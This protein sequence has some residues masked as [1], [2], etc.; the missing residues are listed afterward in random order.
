MRLK[1][2]TEPLPDVSQK[3][4]DFVDS[5]FF[6]KHQRL[7]SP[8]QVRAL[9]Q[10]IKTSPKPKPVIFEDLN[11]LVKFGPDVTVAEAQNLWM[12]KRA[13]RDEVPVP[14]V[15][16]WRV[17]QEDYVFI[18]MEIIHGQTL[19]HLW[20]DLNAA[21]KASLCDQLCQIM[22]TLRQLEQDPQDHYIGSINRQHLLD[23][24]FQSQ[25]KH[26]PFPNIRAFND[27]FAGL[28]QSWLPISQRYDDPSRYLL[29]DDGEI[30][31]THGDLHRENIVV[32]ST[33]P[34]R[35][36]AIVDWEQAGWYPD[37]WEYCKTLYTCWLEDEWRRDW[38]DN[39]LCPR[40]QEF[41]AFI[42]YTMEMGSV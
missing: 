4:Q 7:P 11:V 21:D 10:D 38:I 15:F 3:S 9:S 31:L 36:L 24:V 13:F 18:Y 32:S 41:E 37:Y 40:M 1:C 2:F 23:Y 34:S 26:D 14:E 5:S 35:I 28:P 33:S 30:K 16:G 27:W 22:K 12:V 25:P 6:K 42:Q 17:D 29:P 20:D 39:F 8:A 19:Q